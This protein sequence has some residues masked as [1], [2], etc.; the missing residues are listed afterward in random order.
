MNTADTMHDELKPA[1]HGGGRPT[2]Y[3]LAD[4][5]R[6]PGVTTI[7]GRFKDSGGLIHWSWQCGVDGLDY[8]KV[9]DD[10]ASAGTLAHTWIDDE[11][12]GRVSSVGDDSEHAAKALEALSAFRDWAKQVQLTIVD[13]ERP[14]VSEEHRFGGTYDAIANV[15][16]KLT[17]LDWK[18]SNR[19][20]PE[21][22]IQL[23][24]YRG[25]LREHGQAVDGA[26]LLRVGKEFGDFHYHSFPEQVLDVG[27][28]S[29]TRMRELYDLDATLKKVVG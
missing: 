3:L 26:C 13:T 29:F 6:V 19:I 17:L 4:G 14:L 5:K 16:G 15:N 11:I 9:R 21:Y 1:T 18:T 27:W 22:V 24:A 10:A 8:K 2:R 23:A 7:T 28:K 25:L 20:Y 12:H